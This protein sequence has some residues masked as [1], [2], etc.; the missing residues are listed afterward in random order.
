MRATENECVG[1]TDLG[2]HCL[3]DS[4]PN[5][6]VVRFYCDEC[7][8]EETLYETE[9]GELCSSCLLK[10]FPIVQRSEW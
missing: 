8:I 4:C 9:Y 7:G 5:R 1:C 10:M 2:L 3:G 6:S